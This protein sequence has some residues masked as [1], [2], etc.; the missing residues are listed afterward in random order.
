MSLSD[1]ITRLTSGPAEVLGLDSGTL[2][3]GQQADLCLI[4][5]QAV[6]TF[7]H[8]QMLSRGQNAPCHDWEFK[9]RVCLTLLA[10]K[11]VYNTLDV[12]LTGQD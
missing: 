10:G 3:P 11:P 2:S 1:A 9:G 12:Q 7:R 5:P 4:D 6:W 8:E